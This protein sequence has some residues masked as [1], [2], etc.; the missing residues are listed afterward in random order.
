VLVGVMVTD[1]DRVVDLVA[2]GGS[3]Y[4]FFDKGADRIVI[5]QLPE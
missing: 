1:P 4:H 2:E 3:G 5:Q